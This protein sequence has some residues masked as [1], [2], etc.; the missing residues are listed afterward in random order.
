MFTAGEVPELNMPD[1]YKCAIAAWYSREGDRD[2][3]G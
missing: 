2:V 3:G 1:G